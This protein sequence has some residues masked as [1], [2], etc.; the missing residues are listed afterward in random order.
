MALLVAAAACGGG[1]GQLILDLRTDLRAGSDFIDIRTRVFLGD[2]T[3]VE[4]EV[5]TPAPA[6]RDLS[7]GFRVAEI[8]G[9]EAGPTR[10]EIALLDGASAVVADR[11]IRVEV[12][13]ATA[14][15]VSVSR[16]CTG[17]VCPGASDAPEA[18]ECLGGRCVTPMCA[19]GDATACEVP[20]LSL[21]ELLRQS[22]E[23]SCEAA[24]ACLGAAFDFAFRGDDCA[25]YLEPRVGGAVVDVLQHSLVEGRV[26]YHPEA[27]FGCLNA[28]RTSCRGYGLTKQFLECVDAIEG[29]VELGGDCLT[30]FDCAGVES[31][32]RYDSC[33][34]RC[35]PRGAVGDSC[36]IGE[37]CGID[38]HCTD[39]ACAEVVAEGEPCVEGTQAC[40]YDS[41]CVA[42]PPGAGA[43]CVKNAEFFAAGDGEACGP[44]AGEYCGDGLSC[45]V[46]S[47]TC[48]PKATSGGACTNAFPDPC[49][50]AEY[51]D[52]TTLTCTALPLAGEV[53]AMVDGVPRCGAGHQCD[54]G[55]CVR[56]LDVGETCTSSLEC[57]TT[58]CI[59]GRCASSCE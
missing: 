45:D 7:T 13:G 44:A 27:A 55:T 19:E 49:P 23:A 8:G 39:G 32:C 2:E 41:I 34:G 11:T 22:V 58:L 59:L 5:V 14:I 48:T 30:E 17:V 46:M 21:A 37:E 10:V 1:D 50:T 33:P 43:T 9:L 35:E 57:T 54:S 31:Y 47:A 18:T 56:L 51:C 40:A 26:N 25:S 3:T 52:S 16:T 20:E 28:L 42:R 53:C 29:T 24:S 36:T 4:R 12:S 38:L 6:A 15:S